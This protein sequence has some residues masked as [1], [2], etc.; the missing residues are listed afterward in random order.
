MRKTYKRYQYQRDSGSGLLR[1]VKVK[2]QRIRKQK[3]EDEDMDG[4]VS[5][6]EELLGAD[7]QNTSQR[8]NGI[9]VTWSKGLV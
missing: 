9:A 2:Y 5:A 6:D 3:L 4:L 7:E 8:A 1:K